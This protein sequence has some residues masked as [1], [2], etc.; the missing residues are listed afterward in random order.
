M[1]RLSRP[2]VTITHLVD[3]RIVGGPGDAAGF[4]EFSLC[5]VFLAHR[6]VKPAEPP[7]HIHVLRSQF[8]SHTQFAQSIVPATFIGASSWPAS[9]RRA[10]SNS[11]RAV[12]GCFNC[13]SASPR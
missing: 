9:M 10:F 12:S 1:L 6:P 3:Q 8:G 13:I 4:V 11:G 7:V 2:G 5:L